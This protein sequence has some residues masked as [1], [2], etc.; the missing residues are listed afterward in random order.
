MFCGI[1]VMAQNS[2]TLK[3]NLEKNKVYR[4]RSTT[5]QTV[6][7]T[8]NGNQQNTETKV[9]YTVSLKMIDATPD[10][11]VTEVHFDTLNTSTNTMGKT[12]SINS[13][14]EGNMKSS[15]LGDIMSCIMNRLSKTAVY[16]KID[17]T[18]K[19]L[20]VLNQKM[21]A[22]MILRDTGSVTLT[23]IMR[24]TVKGQM[25][26]SL[27][28]ETLKTIVE[29]FTYRLPGKQVST[30]ETW[31]ILQQKN[32]GGMLL[33]IKSSFHLDEINGSAAKI[34]AE[35]NIAAPENATPMQA[36]GATITY[37]NLKGL[38]KANFV[39][40]INTGLVVQEKAK[41][42]ISGNL[43][44]SAPGFSMQMPMDINGESNV[45]GLEIK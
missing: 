27:S 25:V 1:S 15:E 41:T 6:S 38:S 31:N 39:V 2:A 34:S 24:T 3:L 23:G 12:I 42:H 45:T 33:N 11:I 10:F 35:S 29:M 26:N 20:D 9:N 37:D 13:T 7:Q 44:I 43:G 19:P 40:D 32:S 21:L 16:V 18:G 28:D 8:I 17:Y 14:Q 4:L 5:E 22:D 30:G 36:N